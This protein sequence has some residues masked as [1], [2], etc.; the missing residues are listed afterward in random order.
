MDAYDACKDR[1]GV[2]SAEPQLHGCPKSLERIVLLADEDGH[3]GSL[4]VGEGAAMVVLDKA[5]ASA[6]VAG[7][8]LAIKVDVAQREVD[9]E[10]A[11]V[12]A[13]VK[14]AKKAR[15]KAAGRVQFVVY[16][17]EQAIPTRDV[18]T[19]IDA[20]VEELKGRDDYRIEVV[21]HT[22]ATGSR[23]TN[24]RVGNARAAEIA[25]RL[26]KR[27]VPPNLVS[28]STRGSS[29]PAV[30]VVDPKVPE[31]LNR[32]VEI[33]IKERGDPHIIVHFDKRTKPIRKMRSE[34]RALAKQLKGRSDY[35]I[36]VVG[37]TDPT[38][39]A[40]LALKRATAVA[41]KL[42]GSGISKQRIESSSKGSLVPA[43]E[44]VTPGTLQPLNR[45]VEIFVK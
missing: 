41:R 15:V 17:D 38:E 42:R 4:E 21:G 35:T 30:E 8:G 22:D 44:L 2:S 13:I 29:E 40:S 45:R 10:F 3:V 28:A 16:F 25:K 31:P 23:R 19:Q 14:S 39:D 36:I 26:R 6:E 37:H 12:Y 32:R 34:Y 24:L 27:G 43:V 11:D 20:L 9:R 1:R 33:R 5:Y 18:D 7:D